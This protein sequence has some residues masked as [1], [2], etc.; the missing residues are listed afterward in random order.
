M[1]VSLPELVR[2]DR[3]SEE[4]I[5]T[6]VVEK[7]GKEWRSVCTYLGIDQNEID[8]ALANPGNVKEAFFSLLVI[9]RNGKVPDR[10]VTWAVLLGAMEN[11]GL[12]EICKN[13]KRSLEKADLSKRSDPTE[14]GIV[15]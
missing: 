7:V 4:E 15:Q 9:W 6:F 11:A 12:A 2:D 3:P 14:I 13:I 1:A 8:M 5:R 10:P